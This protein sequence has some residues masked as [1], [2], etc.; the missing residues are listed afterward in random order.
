MFCSHL[1][2]ILFFEIICC[3]PFLEVPFFFFHICSFSPY[4]AYIFCIVLNVW[5]LFIIASFRLLTVGCVIISVLWVLFCWLTF[6]HVSGDNLHRGFC[7]WMLDIVN[8]MLSTRFCSVL[9]NCVRLG[10]KMAVVQSGWVL[11]SATLKGV[12]CSYLVSNPKICLHLSSLGSV[13]FTVV[14]C[15]SERS[16]CELS[17]S[18]LVYSGEQVKSFLPASDSCSTVDGKPGLGN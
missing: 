18:V 16:V 11:W 5:S 4:L 14:G 10:Q 15:S 13:T 2:F 6:F 9:L 17:L 3:F 1:L 12:M 7:Y 8:F